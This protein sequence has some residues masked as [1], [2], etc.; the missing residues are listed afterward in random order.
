[1]STL[2]LNFSKELTATKNVKEAMKTFHAG[3]GQDTYQIDPRQ[4]KF[5]EGFNPRTDRPEYEAYIEQLTQS[6]MA[7]GYYQDKPISVFIA[8]EDGVEVI[9]ATEGHTRTKAVLRAMERGWAG[10][11]IPAV[12]KPRGTTMEDLHFATITTA[13]GLALT[14]Y[15]IGIKCKH[16]VDCGVDIK[17]IAKRI[18]KTAPYINDLLDLVAAPKVIRDMVSSGQVAATAAVKELK[19]HGPKAVVVLQ[20]AMKV[21]TAAGKTKVTGKHIAKAPGKKPAPT[22]LK[23]KGIIPVEYKV[24]TK[25]ITILL[26][27]AL[28]V[29]L[30]KGDM[31]RLVISASE[32]L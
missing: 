23:L 25:S 4:V 17:V 8:V 18:N 27:E 5:M 10:E 22:T 29:E 12:V 6:I 16:L 15:E 26:D 14:P 31:V 3:R 19:A 24:G 13:E 30:L 28:E 9:Y 2:P 11:T 1:M 20:E 32:E 21:A 7:N